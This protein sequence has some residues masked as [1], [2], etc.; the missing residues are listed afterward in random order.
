MFA[1]LHC[2]T[3]ALCTLA[4]RSLLRALEGG[5]Q[6]PVAAFSRIE[7]E[8]D[9]SAQPPPVRMVALSGRVLNLDGS[10]CL[11]ASLTLACS[12]EDDA[13]ELGLRVAQLLKDQGADE[14]L[15]E[16]LQA[17]AISRE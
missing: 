2:P 8:E 7:A 11:E 17:S 13:T 3:T 10:Q 5:C 16:V 15:R 12:T 1:V 4:E 9:A 6:V 14:I